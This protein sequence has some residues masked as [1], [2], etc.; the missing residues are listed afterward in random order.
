M[1]DGSSALWQ[2]QELGSRW[3]MS[4]NAFYVSYAP[5]PRVILWA[6]ANLTKLRRWFHEVRGPT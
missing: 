2:R 4:E 5:S 3:R 6:L 1:S